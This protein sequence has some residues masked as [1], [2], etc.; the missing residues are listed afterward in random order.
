MVKDHVEKQ[1]SRYTPNTSV[2]V[3]KCKCF[4]KRFCLYRYHDKL[5]FRRQDMRGANFAIDIMAFFN[6]GGYMKKRISD[7]NK[8]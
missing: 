7:H 4:G 8:K 1:M 5:K 3:E 2:I 6:D